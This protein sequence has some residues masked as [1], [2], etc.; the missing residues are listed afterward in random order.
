MEQKFKTNAKVFVK[1]DGDKIRQ[2]K[3]VD[4]S[5]GLYHVTF[6]EDQGGSSQLK[7]SRILPSKEKPVETVRRKKTKTGSF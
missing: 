5:K 2:A 1:T 3:I 4:F 7:E 6:L